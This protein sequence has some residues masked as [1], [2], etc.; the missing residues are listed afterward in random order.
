MRLC[1]C[2]SAFF[3]WNFSLGVLS[4]GYG[5]AFLVLQRHVMLRAVFLVCLHSAVTAL[6]NYLLLQYKSALVNGHVIVMNLWWFQ[7]ILLKTLCSVLWS[8]V[9]IS[10]PS[11]LALY[12]NCQKLGIHGI[13][14]FRFLSFVHK[15]WENFTIMRIFWCLYLDRCILVIPKA[16]IL[17]FWLRPLVLGWNI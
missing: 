6:Y 16:K 3:Y 13:V 15:Q 17:L 5:L 2:L 1:F 11:W 4:S 9:G 8:S 14:I 10:K 12:I 7:I